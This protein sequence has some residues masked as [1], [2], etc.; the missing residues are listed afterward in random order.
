MN[1]LL[2]AILKTTKFINRIEIVKI[3]DNQ[4]KNQVLPKDPFSSLYLYPEVIVEMM[5]VPNN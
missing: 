5:S 2:L 1:K 4:F 3:S